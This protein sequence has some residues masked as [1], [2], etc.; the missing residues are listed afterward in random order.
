[1]N[2]SVEA[3]LGTGSSGQAEASDLRQAQRMRDVHSAIIL[4]SILHKIVMK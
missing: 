3:R 4:S 1:M 2:P